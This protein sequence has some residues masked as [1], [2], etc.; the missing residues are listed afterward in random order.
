[1]ES[2]RRAMPEET[3][4]LRRI[5]DGQREAQ[6]KDDR[7]VLELLGR[8]VQEERDRLAVEP[9]EEASNECPACIIL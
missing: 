1:M 4:R 5:E 6:D 3:R 9:I 7:Q 2:R 8:Y